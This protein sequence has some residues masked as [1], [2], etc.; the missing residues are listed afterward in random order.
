M[1]FG[2]GYGNLPDQPGGRFEPQDEAE[3]TFEF[4]RLT[5]DGFGPQAGRTVAAQA[6]AGVTH[7]MMRAP[8]TRRAWIWPLVAGI[9]ALA[10]V[11]AVVVL[12]RAPFSGTPGHP[13][14]AAQHAAGSGHHAP[15]PARPATNANP[16]PGGNADCPV[17]T[18]PF[19]ATLANALARNP[20]YVDARS[21]LLTAAQARRLRAEIGRYDPG[22]IRIAAVRPA[23]ARRGGGERVLANAIASCPGDGAGTTL[24]VN[25][26]SAYLV[27]SYANPTAA[28]QAVAA[29]LNTHASLFAGLADAIRRITIVDKSTH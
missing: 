14:E 25:N 23:T 11:G 7:D 15:A 5:P 24:V 12:L 26:A 22:R 29:A 10:A 2:A 27:T 18:S 6:R 1:S 21:P 17:G 8:S 3:Q 13:R 16:A 28:S 9:T 19:A 20:I 4:R